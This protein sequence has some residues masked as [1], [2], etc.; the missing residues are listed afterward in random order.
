MLSIAELC[1]VKSGNI[2]NSVIETQNNSRLAMESP[3]PSKFVALKHDN[4]ARETLL[5]RLNVSAYMLKCV[6]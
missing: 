3:N 5:P 4:F 6:F 1:D 2:F